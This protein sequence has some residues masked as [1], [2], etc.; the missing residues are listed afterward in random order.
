VFEEKK[1]VL[2]E[3]MTKVFIN[4]TK[5]NYLHIQKFKEVQVEYMQKLNRP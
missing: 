2:E 5:E 4:V 1:K 3:I